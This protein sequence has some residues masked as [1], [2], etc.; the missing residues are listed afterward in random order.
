M[1]HEASRVDLT[2]LPWPLP[3]SGFTLSSGDGCGNLQGYAKGLDTAGSH[4][5]LLIHSVNAAASAY[6][7][8]PLFTHYS[9][10]YPGSISRTVPRSGTPHGG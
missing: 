5:L 1:R 4:P 3:A 7:V 6:E 2:T 10:T 9:A 8:R